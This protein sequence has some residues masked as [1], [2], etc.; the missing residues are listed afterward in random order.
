MLPDRAD[1]RWRQLVTGGQSFALESLA[2]RMLVTRLRLRTHRGGEEAISLA[3]AEAVAFFHRN[4]ATTV[5]DVRAVFGV[6]P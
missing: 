1:P 6:Q 4:E 2:A 3:I 5:R